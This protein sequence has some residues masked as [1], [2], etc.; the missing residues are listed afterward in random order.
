MRAVIIWLLL[1][2]GILVPLALAGASPLLASRE[3]LWILGGMAGI[4]GLALLLVQP[5]L[6]A[7]FLPGISRLLGRQWHRW[8]GT[9]IVL[10]IL[11][12][13]GGL[14]W[15]SPDDIADALLLVAPTPFAVYGVIGLW[16]SILTA[17]LVAARARLPLRYS[18]WRL[19]HN[20]LA[21]LIIVPSLVHAVL[22]EGAMEPISKLALAALVLV[23][24]VFALYRVH[25]RR[26]GIKRVGMAEDR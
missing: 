17:L 14:Y 12:H 8:I 19:L 20:A 1:A 11:L 3:P 7:G 6:A 22:I 26:G 4:I 2:I 13:V 16:C 9:A 24:T 10:A 25:S 21:V 18:A 5:L 15:A 23:A